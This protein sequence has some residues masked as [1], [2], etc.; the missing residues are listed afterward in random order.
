MTTCPQCGATLPTDPRYVTW[1]DACDW[2][3]EPRGAAKKE[4][5]P[6][7]KRRRERALQRAQRLH[8]EMRTQGL[9]DRHVDAGRVLT[10]ALALALLLI[11]L[12]LLG[13]GWLLLVISD[14]SPVGIVLAAILAAT[15][16]VTRPRFGRRNKR[17]IT[18]D[19]G[20]APTLYA[21]VDRICAAE[22]A[23][24]P[25]HIVVEGNFNAA[26]RFVGLRRRVELRIGVPLWAMLDDQQRVAVLA[27]EIGHQV[28]G[29]SMHGL[30]VGGAY[31]T[32]IELLLLFM[33][34]RVHRVT[35]GAAM[36]ELLRRGVATLLMAV[37]RGMELLVAR[38]HQ[39][40]EYRADSVASRVAGRDATAGMLRTLL[41]CES[42]SYAIQRAR[43]RGSGD[44]AYHIVRDHITSIP[45]RERERLRRVAARQGS[46]VDASHPPTPLRMEWV[47]TTP[48]T[49]PLVTM[50]PG[51][52]AAL[53]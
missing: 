50:T 5:R 21:V 47:A 28:N 3:V 34:S 39:R 11:P 53:E 49:K 32:L 38:P 30:V 13:L 15:A 10:Y 16:A 42:C 51:E 1:C 19:R 9:E 25:A 18:V 24:P 40:A 44:D 26:T 6:R 43:S 12:G 2:N 36:S 37:K 17:D 33:P 7:E 8:D 52:S 48:S 14:F 35:F 29:D 31:S 41:L 27:H 22:G 20:A 45:E 46:Q 4:E 23:R